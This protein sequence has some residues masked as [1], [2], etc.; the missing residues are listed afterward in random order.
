MSDLVGNPED[1]F[2][3]NEAHFMVHIILEATKLQKIES[4]LS[5]LF[6][7]KLLIT[8]FFYISKEVVRSDYMDQSCRAR[9]MVPSLCYMFNPLKA[10]SLSLSLSNKIMDQFRTDGFIFRLIRQ[11]RHTL[12]GLKPLNRF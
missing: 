5:V 10:L 11:G 6:T 1:R 3:Q 12:A 4:L 8:W 2:S 7:V 9:R